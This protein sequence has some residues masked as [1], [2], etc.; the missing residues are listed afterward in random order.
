MDSEELLDEV[1][2]PAPFDVR[3]GQPPEP[4]PEPSTGPEEGALGEIDYSIQI[5]N[6]FSMPYS[7][8]MTVLHLKMA[9]CH[10]LRH[11]Q[12]GDLNVY[13]RHNGGTQSNCLSDACL[14]SAIPTRDVGDVVVINDGRREA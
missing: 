5:G 4:E 13:Y 10:S 12:P 1:E 8:N 9:V 11:L 7:R 14:L 2:I 6:D 3:T